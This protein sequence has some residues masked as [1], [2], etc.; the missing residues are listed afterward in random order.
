VIEDAPQLQSASPDG[1][2]IFDAPAEAAHA[3]VT[4]SAATIA[5][6]FR[7]CLR[8]RACNPLNVVRP[9]GTICDRL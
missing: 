8:D 2:W 7:P 6:S 1:L 9:L 3:A 5:R 4:N